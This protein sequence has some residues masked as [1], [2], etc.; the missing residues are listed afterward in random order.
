[1]ISMKYKIL[2]DN[3]LVELENVENTTAS[4]LIVGEEKQKDRGTI[5]ALGEAVSD[6]CVGDKVIFKTTEAE[7][8][9]F[10]EKKCV[11]ITEEAVLA[12]IE[13]DTV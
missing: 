11:V 9:Q 4:G 7:E 13:P 8:M 12:V 6:L 2:H 1:M 5:I 10:E 3:I